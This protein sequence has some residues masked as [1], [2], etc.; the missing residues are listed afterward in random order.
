MTQITRVTIHVCI[1][2]ISSVRMTR[3]GRKEGK[4]KKLKKR[5]GARKEREK[6]IDNERAINAVGTCH[7]K[8]IRKLEKFTSQLRT[9]PRDRLEASLLTHCLQWRIANLTAR[10]LCTQEARKQHAPRISTLEIFSRK[11][12]RECFWRL[13]SPIIAFI[14]GRVQIGWKLACPGLNYFLV[15]DV[16]FFCSWF[17]RLLIPLI[18]YISNIQVFLYYYYTSKGII[19]KRVEMKENWIFMMWYF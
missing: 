18:N 8:H 14:Y 1:V 5:V 12:R 11:A 7:D 3:I 6:E 17:S 13:H 16:S 15:R 10:T 4:K 19:G 9:G 2:D